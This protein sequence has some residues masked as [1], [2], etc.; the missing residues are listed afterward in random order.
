MIV[1]YKTYTDLVYNLL[2][3]MNAKIRPRCDIIIYSNV[4]NTE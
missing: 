3:P 2:Q 1:Y 4:F